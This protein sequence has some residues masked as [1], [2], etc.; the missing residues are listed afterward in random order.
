METV[1]FQCLSF[2]N[3]MSFHGYLLLCLII[4][5]TITIF[6]YFLSACVCLPCPVQYNGAYNMVSLFGEGILVRVV[7]LVVI[8]YSPVKCQTLLEEIYVQS[9]KM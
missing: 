7:I 9:F 1:S 6:Q 4:I 2:E 5:I 8:H 3:Q